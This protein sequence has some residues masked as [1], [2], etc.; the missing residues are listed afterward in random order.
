MS[1]ERPNKWPA[2]GKVTVDAI[3]AKFN[4]EISSAI[5][6]GCK[7]KLVGL[8]S[9]EDPAGEVYARMTKRAMEKVG[10][11]YELRRPERLGLEKAI[12][13]AN[14][15]PSVHGILTYYPVFG[16]GKDAYLRD[17]IS[18]EKDVEGL[19]HRYCYSLYHN[20][21]HIEGSEHNKKCV[22]PCTPLACVKVLESLGAYQLQQPVGK[23]LR[24]RTV[25]I[26]NRSEVVGR[27]L[28]AM[29]AN[30]GALVYSVDEFGM[31]VYSAGA[32]H[33]SIKVEETDKS[34][35]SALASADIV[36]GGVPAKSF[37]IEAQK[38]KPGAICINVAQH[39]NFGDGTETKCVLVP[40]V[41]KVT[42][43]IL[44]RNLLRLYRNFHAPA[45]ST[46]ERLLAKVKRSP[47]RTLGTV[48]TI[49]ALGVGIFYAGFLYG[50]PR[51]SALSRVGYPY[52]HPTAP[53]HT[54]VGYPYARPS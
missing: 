28:A 53:A 34:V 46:T 6:S 48:L 21:R 19:S 37:K 22:L 7:P 25:I 31:L 3:A 1:E 40:A 14:E 17:V 12:L 10:I 5:S 18:I 44:A 4:E 54:Q 29:L 43:A 33:G 24:G 42:I 32:V 16:G 26:Y 9:N 38:L 15:D 35:E 11:E 47:V 30:D 36:V 13:D 50:R 51:T 41:G 45:P 39:M 52:A 8:L 20:I 23:Q 27:P 2:P 49:A